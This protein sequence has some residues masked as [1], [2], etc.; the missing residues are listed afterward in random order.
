MQNQTMPYAVGESYIAHKLFFGAFIPDW[1]DRHEKLSSTAKRVFGRLCRYQGKDG[2]CFPSHR[3]LAHDLGLSDRRIRTVLAELEREGL[4]ERMPPSPEKR[5]EHK[6]TEYSLL[7]HKGI[8]PEDIRHPTEHMFP[9]ATEQNFPSPTEEEFRSLRNNGSDEENNTRETKK[10]TTT[11]QGEGDTVKSIAQSDVSGG[12]SF[13]DK[14]SEEDKEYID[15]KVAYKH[16]RGEIEKSPKIYKKKLISLAHANTMDKS[17]FEMLKQ[18]SFQLKK[19]ENEESIKGK[20]IQEMK[21]LAQVII[22]YF[23]SERLSPEGLCREVFVK[24]KTVPGIEISMCRSMLENYIYPK[25]ARQAK[26]AEYKDIGMPN[27]KKILQS[28]NVNSHNVKYQ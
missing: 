27:V 20:E 11:T 7:W 28:I 23:E 5:G 6:S 8:K 15:L 25:E 24:N 1:V 16:S 2:R 19:K 13:E 12:F 9:R 4:I 26:M 22:D 21:R 17:D 18:W 14:L 10:R 3:R